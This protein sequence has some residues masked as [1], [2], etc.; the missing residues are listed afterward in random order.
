M[1]PDR[2]LVVVIN[3]GNYGTKSAK[4]RKQ[5]VHMMPHLLDINEDN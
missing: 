5:G 1:V 2:S 3:S 4:V